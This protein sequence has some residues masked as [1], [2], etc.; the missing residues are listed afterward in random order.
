MQ[1]LFY[2]LLT[3]ALAL[4]FDAASLIEADVALIA[5]LA[6]INVTRLA[7][8]LRHLVRLAEAALDV[9]AAH[10]WA[11]LLLDNG[12]AAFAAAQVVAATVLLHADHRQFLLGFFLSLRLVLRGLARGTGLPLPGVGL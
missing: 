6:L 4:A 3:L 5:F 2:C 8:L 10:A 1:A 11:N 12:C 9:G 7:V